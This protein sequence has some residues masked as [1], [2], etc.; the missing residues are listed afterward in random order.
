MRA[1]RALSALLLAVAAVGLAAPAASAAT[2]LVTSDPVPHQEFAVAPGGVSLA[3]DHD[4]PDG[5]AKI[6]I[7]D[8]SGAHVG[9]GAVEYWGS[10]ISMQLVNDLPKGTYT[11]KFRVHDAEGVPEGGAF[12]FSVGPGRW[13]DPLPDAE[14]RGQAEQPPG[15]ANPDPYETGAAI[16]P[17]PSE[18]DAQEVSVT[19]TPTPTPTVSQ[20]T[21]SGQTEPTATAT[22]APASTSGPWPWLA[23]GLVVLATLGVGAWLVLR[24]RGRR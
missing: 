13:T 9:V 18:P 5:T 16:T 11:V 8:S 21:P 14:W 22:P 12:Q 20:T 17:D 1:F 23:G 19:P 6:L 2:S 4:I 24:N 15:L 7:L 3:F 10:T